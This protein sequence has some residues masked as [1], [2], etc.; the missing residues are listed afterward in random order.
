MKTTQAI[1]LLSQLYQNMNS[2]SIKILTR[3]NFH[4][5]LLGDDKYLQIFNQHRIS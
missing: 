2:I 1:I 3:K 4:I 5:N